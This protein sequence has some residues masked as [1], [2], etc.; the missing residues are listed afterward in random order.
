MIIDHFR[1]H[2]DGCFAN[3]TDE[4]S[5]LSS[6]LACPGVGTTCWWVSLMPTT[7]WTFKPELDEINRSS[8]GI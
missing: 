6:N 3:R 5:I 8:I 4:E 2:S 1:L 7:C